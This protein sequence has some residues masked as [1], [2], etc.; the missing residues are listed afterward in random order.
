[1]CIISIVRRIHLK[2]FFII[3]N[4]FDIQHGIKSKYSDFHS[5][6]RS[7]YVNK[8]IMD[9]S[10]N[11]FFPWRYS[12][13]KSRGVLG[14]F[15]DSELINVFGFLD[16]CLTKSENK[17]SL[18]NFYVNSDWSSVES[19][20]ANL[21]LYEFFREE[22]Y[23]PTHSSE[24]DKAYDIAECFKYLYKVFWI[25]VK[26]IEI[27]SVVPIDA[28]QEL[29]D[30]ENDI[31]FTFNYTRTLE[32]VY[33]AKQVRH[34]HG[35][36]GK[37]LLFGHEKVTDIN[38]Y[39]CKN[40]I[41]DYCDHAIKVLMEITEK[42]TEKNSCN[43]ALYYSFLDKDITDIYSYG[44]SFSDVDLPYIRDICKAIDTSKIVWHLSDFDSNEKREDFVRRIVGCG[45]C[46]QFTT[47]S[48]VNS[49]VKMSNTKRKKADSYSEYLKMQKEYMGRSG[50]AL[51]QFLLDYYTIGYTRPTQRWKQSVWLMIPRLIWICFLC[52]FEFIAKRLFHLITK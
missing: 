7:M 51:Q 14:K 23:Q 42:D 19:T 21:D 27:D 2:K 38:G 41:P 39:C 50:F 45:F 8:E 17:E 15:D 31:F 35:E 25:W 3:G 37:R 44:F 24:E 13:P 6:M 5:F 10:F 34:V 22:Y 48:I 30:C 40:G 46:G 49:K 28:F 9:N 11:D 26:E 43:L 47:F 12:V 52:F 20:L 29:F 33:G 32:D 16:Y 18:F 4:G 1:M 36:Q